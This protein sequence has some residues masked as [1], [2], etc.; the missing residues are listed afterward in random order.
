MIADIKVRLWPALAKDEGLPI[1]RSLKKKYVFFYDKVDLRVV[2]VAVGYKQ[3]YPNGPTV[4]ILEG[5]FDA[6]K[7]ASGTQG[8]SKQVRDH[9]LFS[10]LTI[11]SRRAFQRPHNPGLSLGCLELISTIQALN[12]SGD[13]GCRRGLANIWTNETLFCKMQPASFSTSWLK[14]YVC[15]RLILANARR[16]CV[17]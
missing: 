15:R 8:A 13:N 11:S 9:G 14:S 7:A 2:R 12:P 17:F 5:G 1:A 16:N 4:I 10:L 3:M 6:W